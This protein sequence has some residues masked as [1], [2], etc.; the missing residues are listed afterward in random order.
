MKRI[1]C[2]IFFSLVSYC[3][4][5]AQEHSLSGTVKNARNEA[6]VYANVQLLT[7]AD[8]VMV[9]GAS[10]DE[11]GGF[12][13][14]KIPNGLY[15][16]KASY[17]GNESGLR[18][19]EITKDASLEPLIINEDAQVLQ[20][21]TVRSQ[22]PRLERQV[23]RLVF[24]IENTAFSDG[25]IWDALKRT[26]SVIIVNDELTVKGSSAVGILIN[27]RKVNLPKGDIINLL[28]GASASDVEAIEVI[29]NPPS[30][31]NA[32]DG[33]LINIR[34][35]RNLVAG[36][37]G[38]V[39]NRY[40]QGILPKHTVGTDHYFKGEK[41]GFSINYSFT[42][43]R[44]V[45][46][47]TDITDFIENGQ[48]AATWTEQQVNTSKRQRHNLSAFF[49]HDFDAKNRL[50]LSTIT[51][52]Q[53]RISRFYNS[54]A[55]IVGDTLGG[56]TTINDSGRRE[57]NTSYY[58]DYT[59]EL[60]TPGAE[61]SFNSHY[62]YYDYERDQD[63]NT[64]LFGLDGN[65][66]GRDDF[67]TDSDQRIDLYNI[68]MDYLTPLGET[69]NFESGLR[70]AGI[71]S[72]S[73][74]T[75]Q[76]F[77]RERAGIDPTE[78]G[79]FKYDE[80]IYAAY[81]SLGAKWDKWELKAGLRAEYTETTGELDL[82]SQSRDNDYLQLFPS[83]SVQF[84]HSEKSKFN[85]YY[86]RRIDRPRYADISPFVTFTS[87]FSTVEGDINLQPATR[88]YVASGYTFD[89]SY[90]I[91]LFY[92]NE[93]NSLG[94]L[95]FQDNDARLLRFIS[96]NLERD[97]SYGIDFTINK[98]ITDFWNCYLLLS[99]AENKVVFNTLDSSE[100]VENQIFGG[101]LESTQSFTFLEDGSLTADLNFFYLPPSLYQNQRI[102][103]F[104]AINL[105]LR[106]TIWDRQASI[107]L[108]VQDIF[109]QGNQFSTRDYLNQRGTSL[110]RQENRLLVLGLRYKFGNTKIRDNYKSKG[111]DE[112]DRL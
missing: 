46:K 27:G 33:V 51:V 25:A 28:S 81:A 67:V 61:L 1:L 24:N 82:G 38:A 45:V 55:S 37:N 66:N 56:Y 100:T 96:S 41:T 72:T 10:T 21:V 39:Y 11:N 49:D 64:V 86:Y 84:T 73:E 85:T 59:R 5:V 6:I 69:M 78:T 77:D 108:G 106:K 26:P 34:K 74:V 20:E 12:E 95:I 71:N 105:A 50:S 103:S 19:V 99:L 76:G 102:D 87:N 89:D 104:G 92:R 54:E 98:N 4:L 109:N 88:H 9:K 18:A 53:P 58:L 3:S 44:D 43:D 91:E 7:A 42:H 16:V 65:P 90:T 31:Y 15:L 94:E 8:S 2:P 97:I 29:T 30:K 110:Q 52:W 107:S 68:Q 93:R 36:Y 13:I 47:N 112:R 60:A 83:A 101:L 62:T 17:I 35:K 80:S 48:V 63:L 79:N 40:R 32:E 57:L 22:K 14:V 70:Y 111:T 23:D 75:Q